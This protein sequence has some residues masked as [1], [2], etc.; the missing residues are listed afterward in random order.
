MGGN[1][2]INPAPDPNDEDG[3]RRRFEY[4]KDM[5]FD[6]NARATELGV[7]ALKSSMV[8]NGAAAIALLAFIGQ[9]AIGDGTAPRLLGPLKL[10]VGGVL[11]AALATGFGYLRM[12]FESLFYIF[13]IKKP[14][15]GKK[16]MTAANGSLYAAIAL[17]FISYVLFAVAMFQSGDALNALMVSKTAAG[18]R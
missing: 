9:A 3:K 6:A 18:G 14:D 5:I 17:A 4:Y 10:L 2:S 12:Y 11:T 8:I 16:W 13:E 15:T 7:A 1:S